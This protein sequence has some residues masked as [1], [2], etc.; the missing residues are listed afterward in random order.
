MKTDFVSKDKTLG[1][2]FIY[3]KTFIRHFWQYPSK[4]ALNNGNKIC[5]QKPSPLETKFLKFILVA[6]KYKTIEYKAFRDKCLP[7]TILKIISAIFKGLF[8]FLQRWFSFVMVL[9]LQGSMS[10][11]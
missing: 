11:T 2:Q 5:L 8:F 4:Y 7:P 6:F 1:T 10:H 9:K 3:K